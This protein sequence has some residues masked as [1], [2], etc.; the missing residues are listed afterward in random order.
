LPR[1]PGHIAVSSCRAEPAPEL[2]RT[3]QR[4]SALGEQLR[5]IEQELAWP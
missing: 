1:L 4:V 2:E 5:Q 3:A